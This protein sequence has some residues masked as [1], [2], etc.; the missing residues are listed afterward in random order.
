MKLRVPPVGGLIVA[1]LLSNS[2]PR[3]TAAQRP[4]PAR[5]DYNSGEYL[6]RTFCASCHG[7][8]AKGDVPSPTS[9]ADAHPT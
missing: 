5:Q 9:F 3:E 6:Y 1:T 7:E 4:K 2:T 8:S